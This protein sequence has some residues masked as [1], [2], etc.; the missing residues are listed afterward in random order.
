MTRIFGWVGVL[1]VVAWTV[2]HL[3]YLGPVTETT[4]SWILWLVVAMGSVA[5]LA[6]VAFGLATGGSSP[7]WFQFVVWAR[8]AAA[9]VGCALVVVG[10]LHYRDTEPQ[11]EIRW[12]VLGLLALAT[13]GI[14][15]WWVVRT[16]RRTL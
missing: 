12:L 4:M 7:A 10:V 3:L 6:V 9:I 2:A 16:Q 13:A 5:A 14:V 1:L 15:H 8:A 11:G